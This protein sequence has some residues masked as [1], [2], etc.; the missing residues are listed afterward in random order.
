[1][2]HAH[3]WPLSAAK[4]TNLCMTLRQGHRCLNVESF[5]PLVSPP[6]PKK[7]NLPLSL[8]SDPHSSCSSVVRGEQTSLFSACV[9]PLRP[10]EENAERA[11]DTWGPQ[12]RGYQTPPWLP[13]MD[14]R[15]QLVQTK[16]WL[17]NFER[18]PLK[19]ASV[20]SFLPPNE[21]MLR[22]WNLNWELAHLLWAGSGGLKIP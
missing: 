15:R 18:N 17:L 20:L 22:R 9:F 3:T 7:T 5:L 14:Y 10:D 19:E 16:S 13:T 6:H 11:E 2:L 4:Q 21:K 12:P 1:M 8:P